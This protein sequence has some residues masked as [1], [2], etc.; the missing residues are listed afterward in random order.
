MTPEQAL[1]AGQCILTTHY[2][3]G[4]VEVT[5]ADPHIR[6]DLAI[7]DRLTFVHGLLKV[8]DINPVLYRIDGEPTGYGNGSMYV[9]ATRIR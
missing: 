2:P 4:A 9:E 3:S 1:N 6:I 8:G 7:L 5:Q